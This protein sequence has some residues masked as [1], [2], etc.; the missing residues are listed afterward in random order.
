MPAVGVP[1]WAEY[2]GDTDAVAILE[3]DNGAKAVY[4]GTTAHSVGLNDWSREHFRVDGRLG[5]ALLEH[6]RVELFR[7]LPESHARQQVR[8][9]EGQLV[10]LVEGRKWAHSLLI[11][12]FVHWLDGGPAPRRKSSPI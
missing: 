2:A 11:E 4:E 8:R 9:G 6:R 10:P 7:R 1:D 5:S 3:F 12:Q